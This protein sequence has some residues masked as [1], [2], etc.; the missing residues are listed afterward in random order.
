MKNMQGTKS[1]WIAT[2]VDC[3]TR[4]NVGWIPIFVSSPPA[5]RVYRSNVPGY[6][7]LRRK[8]VDPREKGRVPW[9]RLSESVSKIGPARDCVLPSRT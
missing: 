8:R 9:G 5:H 3:E 4:R 6:G 2:L 1:R 7:K